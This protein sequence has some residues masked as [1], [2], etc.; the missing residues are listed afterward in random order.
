MSN[1]KTFYEE[2]LKRE[3]QKSPPLICEWPSKLRDKIKRDIKQATKASALIGSKCPTKKGSTNQSIGNQVEAYITEKLQSKL[4][5]FCLGHCKGHGYPDKIL[6]Q[7]SDDHLIPLE[8]KATSKWD[9]SDSNRR[10]LT[11]SSCKL[12]KY[13]SSPIYHLLLTAH[14]SRKN[15]ATII[16]NLRLDFLEPTTVVKIRLEASVNHK[17]LANAKHHNITI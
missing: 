14:Y 16:D 8:M 17:S 15:N 11:S 1:L 5:S 10:V 7:L 4:K 3:N 13:F 2:L 9:P 12:R 6:T